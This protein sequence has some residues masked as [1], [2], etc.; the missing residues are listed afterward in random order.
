MIKEGYGKIPGGI[1][2][3]EGYS[4]P[5]KDKYS[6][7]NLCGGKISPLDIPPPPT[8]VFITNLDKSYEEITSSFGD[9]FDYHSS[10]NNSLPDELLEE[11]G[12]FISYDVY[13]FL[14]NYPLTFDQIAIYRFMEHVP[15]KDMLYFTY[16]LSTTVE[17]GG[18]IDVIVP[19]ARKLSLMLVEEGDNITQANDIL[20]TTELLNEPSC[21]HASLWTKQRAKYYFELEGR[22]RVF[23]IQENF[24]FDGRDIYLRFFAERIK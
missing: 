24:E 1:S 2:G 5:E 12:L 6:I 7:L 14:E 18:Y 22:F 17:V 9:I 13:K 19:D 11:Q 15:L 23:D 4:K 10:F 21:P 16:L 3:K 8:N 20:L